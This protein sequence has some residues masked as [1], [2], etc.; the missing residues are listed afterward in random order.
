MTSGQYANTIAHIF[1]S[2]IDSRIPL[3]PLQ[4]TDGLL[5]SSAAAVG[6]TG[7]ELIGIQRA[8]AAIAAQV[9]DAA[10][11]D[12]LVPCKP[13]AFD[14]PDDVC[15][16]KFLSSVGRLLFR[17]P[18]DQEK[19]NALVGDARKS[20]ELLD[21][22]YA[23]LAVVLE[24]MLVDPLVLMVT[25]VAEPD[26]ERPGQQRLDAFS[27][28]SR[29]SFF[30]WDAAP[31]DG[32]LK[33]AESGEIL[34]PAGRARL[35][36]KM[37]ASPRLE[38]GVRAFFDDMFAF[39]DFENLSKDAAFYPSLV[40]PAL[41]D[42]REQTLRTVF[43]HLI[44]RKN[45]YRDLFTTRATFMSPALA[46]IY[47]VPT[48][49]GWVPY[50]FPSSAPRPG[51]L[52]QVSFLALHAY[53]TRSSPTLRGKALRELLLCQRVPPPP[54]NVDFS[55]LEDPSSP[56]RTVR[57]RVNFHLQN[58][59]CAG[60]H[61][62]T[63]PMGLALENFNGGG[64]YRD[65]ENGVAIDASGNLDGKTFTTLDGLSQTLRD[66]PAVP[67][68]FVRRLYSYGTGGPLSRSDDSGVAELTAQFAK[69]GYRM[70][71]LLRAIVLSNGFLQVTAPAVS[72][73]A[74]ASQL[75][76]PDKEGVAE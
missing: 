57:D 63:D 3:A 68:C 33:A 21:D 36:E 18:L 26:P 12:F 24:G 32:V 1:G 7:G 48:V 76:G 31:D 69:A 47:E 20:A 45:D 2:D 66:H 22:F 51:L 35:V 67:N 37:L 59:V 61:K 10:H 72:A 25:D 52:T 70:P 49:P 54:P 34:T 55:A 19:L 50:E 9:V 62:I 75:T 23:G 13:L 58:P 53:P 56:F 14:K 39:D 28:A 17:R 27:L 15:A 73:A 60:C 71:D 42:A 46:P 40:R 5:A 44:T 29:L 38:A 30:L 4:R 64:Q 6:V 74:S 11:R 41:A 65:H 43:D 8:A 16:G